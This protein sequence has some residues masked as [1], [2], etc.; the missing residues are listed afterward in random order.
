MQ[1][2]GD[3]NLVSTNVFAPHQRS[4]MHTVTGA[5]RNLTLAST[6]ALAAAS[7][8][9]AQAKLEPVTHNGMTAQ[10]YHG[11]TPQFPEGFLGLLCEGGKTADD[12]KT[13]CVELN[14]D[15]SGTWENDYGPGRQ[16]P[17]AT[18]EWRVLA[19]K[20]GTVTRVDQ[21]ERQTFTLIVT[22]KT[23]YYSQQIGSTMLLRA[24][25][26]PINGMTRY[27]IDSKY[28]DR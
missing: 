27:L 5:L 28:R 7:T 2:A 25:R 3:V 4:L 20:E 11:A 24:S 14:P 19:D 15:G 16:E 12:A 17:K 23:K 26:F 22:F 8:A 18:I 1:A 10:G 9:H 6:L 21:G 13:G